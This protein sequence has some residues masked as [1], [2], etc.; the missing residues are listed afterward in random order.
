[1]NIKPVSFFPQEYYMQDKH[2]QILFYLETIQIHYFNKDCGTVEETHKYYNIHLEIKYN[3]IN[4]T[5]GK[6][7]YVHFK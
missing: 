4:T 6:N 5:L 7:A 1:M 3:Q 2:L